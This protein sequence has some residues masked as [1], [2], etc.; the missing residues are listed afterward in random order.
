MFMK[1]KFCFLKSRSRSQPPVPEDVLNDIKNLSDSDF[2]ENFCTELSDSDMDDSHQNLI[3]Q[4][5]AKRRM[6]V[7]GDPDKPHGYVW[8]RRGSNMSSNANTNSELVGSSP[9]IVEEIG[10]PVARSTPRSASTIGM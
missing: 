6:S 10:S 9:V 5:V 4:S 3:E 1:I 8:V 2:D 7:V